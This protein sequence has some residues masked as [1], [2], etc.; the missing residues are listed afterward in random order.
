M[1]DTTVQAAYLAP[2][3]TSGEPVPSVQDSE[4]I[5]FLPDLPLRVLGEVYREGVTFVEQD[6]RQVAQPGSFDLILC[7]GLVREVPDISPEVTRGMG[8]VRL[9]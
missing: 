2:A 1:I 3:R 6:V 8:S 9:S 5:Q 7:R 4:G